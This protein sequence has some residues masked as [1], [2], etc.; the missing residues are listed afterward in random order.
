MLY[1]STKRVE[2][3]FMKLTEYLKQMNDDRKAAVLFGVT[4]RA[5]SS[6]RRGE[7][8]PRPKHAKTIIEKSPVTIEGIYGFGD[9]VQSS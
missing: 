7:R 1:V 8:T 6:W 3:P 9:E 4:E 2:S 5:I